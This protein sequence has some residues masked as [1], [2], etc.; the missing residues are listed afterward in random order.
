MKKLSKRIIS[1]VLALV[2]AM[3]I[4]VIALPETASAAMGDGN[5][6]LEWDFVGAKPAKS[7]TVDLGNGS[8][9][10]T[11]TTSYP[12]S[13]GPNI[14]LHNYGSS[15]DQTWHYDG[16]NGMRTSDGIAYFGNL[17]NYL[18]DGKDIDIKF[19]AAI[20]ANESSSGKGIFAIGSQYV[21]SGDA[22]NSANNLIYWRND[23]EMQFKN[24]TDIR[25]GGSL[26]PA[27]DVF[28][29][30]RIH[31]DYLKKR[32]NVYRDNILAGS[33]QN[34][35]ITKDDFGCLTIGTH[36]TNWFG[37]VTI[38]K[39]SISNYNSEELVN[40][41][42]N[43]FD[44]SGLN[45][46]GSIRFSGGGDAYSTNVIYS[47]NGDY[48]SNYFEESIDGN[49]KLGFNIYP[50]STR[51]IYAYEGSDS[52]IGFPLIDKVQRQNKSGC[53]HNFGVNY[54]AVSDATSGRWYLDADWKRTSGDRNFNDNYSGQSDKE[55]GINII[56][57]QVGNYNSDGYSTWSGCN[58]STETKHECHNTGDTITHR[59]IVKFKN[60]NISFSNGYYSITNSN[61]PTFKASTDSW[62]TWLGGS[63]YWNEQAKWSAITINGKNS[64]ELRVLDVRPFK[65]FIG[66]GSAFK[67]AVNDILGKKW[68]YTSASLATYYDAVANVMKFNINGFDY[69]D[70]TK[71]Q[72]AIAEMNSVISN[73]DSAVSGLTLNEFTITY[74][75]ADGNVTEYVTAGNKL[76][77]IPSNSVTAH[78]D[79][80]ANH[81]KI[82]GWTS[83]SGTWDGA[84]TP[85]N[86]HIPH[87]NETY[88]ETVTSTSAC[89]GGAG[90]PVAAT[91]EHNGYTP[92]ECS[93]CHHETSRTYNPLSWTAYNSALSDY[94]TKTTNGVYTTSTV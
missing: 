66:D 64:I 81:H 12:S 45:T 82:Y 83:A 44:L 6:I 4:V 73:Y 87:T 46:T 27:K 49:N 75:R 42:I 56:S 30:Y 3:P 93:V 54:I 32:I 50:A 24:S 17:K 90:T 78:D 31:F 19:T 72:A 40:N 39:V 84:T 58:N 68:M 8:Y 63:G 79:S 23:G 91:S 86:T 20:H 13:G 36:V 47:K 60:S 85:S 61:M 21:D 94:N 76:A 15:N 7:A 10:A 34:D 48:D 59:N 25:V 51:V 28:Y 92:Y 37:S 11:V 65:N 62:I 69:S 14:T 16:N 55:Y 80:N 29:E 89:T 52:V 33:V 70:D 1:L 57:Y 5:K 26:S 38:K 43:N 74:Q 53:T 35:S 2:M 67:S 18:A 41:D 77:G 88:Y 22:A 71:L 9:D